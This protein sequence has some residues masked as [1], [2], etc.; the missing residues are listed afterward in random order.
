[1][2]KEFYRISGID[3]E[4]SLYNLQQLTFEVTGLCNLK[5]I[6]CCYG[7]YYEGFDVNRFDMSF[8]KAKLFIDYLFNL[9]SANNISDVNQDFY[10]SFYGG[11]PLLNIELIKKIVLYAKL[12]LSTYRKIKF[13]MTTNAVLLDKYIDYIVDNDIML[14]VSLDGDKNANGFR[15]ARN[16]ESMYDKIYENILFVKELYPVFFKN[17]VEFNSVLHKKNSVSLIN[18]FFKNNFGK[19]S[20]ITELSQDNLKEL[21]NTVFYKE[22]YRSYID[23]NDREVLLKKQMSEF[24]KKHIKN[25]FDNYNILLYTQ[26]D[27][28]LFQTATCIPFSKKVFI[29]AAG[30]ILP[31]EKISHHYSYGV[32]TKDSVEL[33]FN[34]IANKYNDLLDSIYDIC[35]HC[36]NKHACNECMYKIID[37]KQRCYSYLS[38]EK[39]LEYNEKMINEVYDNPYLYNEII[40][41]DI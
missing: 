32:I 17:R 22:M 38:K 30:N 28:L 6:Y 11:E 36:Y 3:I 8:D 31:C 20:N 41:S 15:L 14:L 19:V 21:H 18:S 5:C 39:Y 37:N 9:W 40:Q 33:D 7:D 13:T 2:R 16:G 4:K 35:N 27:L 25:Y 10:I 29:T 12:K 24:V 1:M 26:N 34:Y 23:E